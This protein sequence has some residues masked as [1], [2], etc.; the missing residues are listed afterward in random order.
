M[1]I[2]NHT[3]MQ[4]SDADRYKTIKSNRYW[5][6]IITQYYPYGFLEDIEAVSDDIK[7]LS[8]SFNENDISIG[9][10]AFIFDSKKFKPIPWRK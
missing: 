9:D 1:I 10:R 2:R 8:D 7:A 4:L 5:L 6:V 3:L